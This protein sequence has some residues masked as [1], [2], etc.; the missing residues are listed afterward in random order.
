MADAIYEGLLSLPLYPGMTD[1][2]V[3]DVVVALREI[4]ADYRPAMV[5]PCQTSQP[6]AHSNTL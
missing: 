1:E 2:D 5:F 3:Q 4:L 6:A